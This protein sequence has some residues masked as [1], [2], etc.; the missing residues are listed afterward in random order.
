MCSSEFRR[1][2]PRRRP[3]PLAHHLLIPRQEL[4]CPLSSSGRTKGTRPWNLNE[5]RLCHV[6]THDTERD[7]ESIARPVA[8]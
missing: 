8:P 5:G 1:T 6:L 3:F 7:G 4:R 2:Y